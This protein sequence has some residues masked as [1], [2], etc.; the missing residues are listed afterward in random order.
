[1]ALDAGGSESAEVVHTG[2]AD[3]ADWLVGPLVHQ[4][5]NGV[6]QR[7]GVAVVVLGYDQH[8]GV[9]CLDEGT[10][11]TGVLLDVV[12]QARMV[13]LVHEGQVPRE[14]VDPL[15]IEGARTP[16]A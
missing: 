12:A 8:K 3:K 5:I 10:P 7:R 6:L 9:G 14:Q 1:M 4:V 15:A 16:R 11:A 13:R 2:F